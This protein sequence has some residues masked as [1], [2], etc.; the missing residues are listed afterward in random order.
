MRHAVLQFQK[1]H[2]LRT[3]NFL[4]AQKVTKNA[5]YLAK[6]LAGQDQLLSASCTEKLKYSSMNIFLSFGDPFTS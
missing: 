6:T 4:L 5:F 3:S 1:Q 2:R